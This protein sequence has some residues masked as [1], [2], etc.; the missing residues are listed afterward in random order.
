M[1]N[2]LWSSQFVFFCMILMALYNNMLGWCLLHSLTSCFF[3]FQWCVKIMKTLF[4]AI[5]T[6]NNRLLSDVQ[7]KVISFDWYFTMK[8]LKL[9]S[10]DSKRRRMHLVFL[11]ASENSVGFSLWSRYLTVENLNIYWSLS[12]KSTAFECPYSNRISG[13][14]QCINA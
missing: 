8:H 1:L 6:L 9:S 7:K 3:F 5:S 10:V 2:F 11:N 14:I 13:Q 12:N 4:L